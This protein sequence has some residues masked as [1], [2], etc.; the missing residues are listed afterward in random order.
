MKTVTHL[1]HSSRALVF[2][3]RPWQSQERN[4]TWTCRY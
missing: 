4:A 1:G 2:Q 3:E